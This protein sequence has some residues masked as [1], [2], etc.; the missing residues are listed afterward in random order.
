MGDRAAL[1]VVGAVES[2]AESNMGRAAIAA[3]GRLAEEALVQAGLA[4]RSGGLT[5]KTTEATVFSKMPISSMPVKMFRILREDGR[6]LYSDFDW[7]QGGHLPNLTKLGWRPGKPIS[8]LHVPA[9]GDPEIQKLIDR[10]A[11]M[12][13]GIYLAANPTKWLDRPTDRVFEAYLS[14]S[15][16]RRRLAHYASMTGRSIYDDYL[17]NDFNATGQVSLV[18]ELRSS[19]LAAYKK[20]LAK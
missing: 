2:A 14:G 15:E 9:E 19:E 20:L 8:H 11:G 6:G 7:N 12:G 18:R 13:D 1:T 5:I 10:R 16:D 4:T 17:L 3:A